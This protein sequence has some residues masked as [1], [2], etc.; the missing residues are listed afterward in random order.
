MEVLQWACLQEC[1]LRWECLPL[2]DLACLLG[3]E[4]L[5][6]WEDHLEWED[7]QGWVDLLG[8]VDPLGCRYKSKFAV[9]IIMAVTSAIQSKYILWL[10]IA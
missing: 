9:L 4:G 5:Q 1:D 8:W 7:H 6:E 3:W 2:E 10:L